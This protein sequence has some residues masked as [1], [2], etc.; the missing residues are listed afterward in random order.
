MTNGAQKTDD[1]AAAANNAAQ[2]FD[3]YSAGLQRIQ[4]DMARIRQAGADAG[5]RVDGD[6][7]LEPGPPPPAP[8]P[9]PTGDSATPEAVAAHNQATAAQ[10][11]YANLT[12]AY[13][14][15]QQETESVRRAQKFLDDTLNNAWNDIKSKWFLT[16]GDLAN[17]AVETLRTLH[18]SVLLRESVRLADDAAKFMAAATSA[19][20]AAPDV[21]YRD[22]DTGRTMA[23]SADDL[24][25]ESADAKA[26]AGKFA[27]KAG[28]ALA[29][30]GIIYD[31]A[32]TDK[33]VGQAIVSG[34][35]GFAASIAAGAAT[36]AI[37]GSFV[38]VPGVGTAV[39][40][41]VG[42]AVGLFTSGAIDSLYQNGIGAV[43]D[44]VEAGGQAI[45]NAGKAI[46]DAAGAVG[47]AIGD[48]WDAIF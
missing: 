31:I 17:G 33:P 34:A 43:G 44:A 25:R 24:A 7:I 16:I 47:D 41:V 29:A 6:L 18:S 2:R 8:G 37:V 45:A 30:A 10:N 12:A 28:G 9:S 15:A 46:G 5:L 11:T 23:Q 19:S 21:V 39:G 35:G 42:T 13:A 40:A 20:G 26:G 38:P 48:A 22:V 4:G 3:E 27:L 1:L 36:G 32:V 14:K